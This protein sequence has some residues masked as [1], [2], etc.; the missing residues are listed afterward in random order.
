[1]QLQEQREKQ[2]P[3]LLFPYFEGTIA[4]LA[5]EVVQRRQNFQL[6]PSLEQM[7]KDILGDSFSYNELQRSF[8]PSDGSTLELQLAPH[9]AKPDVMNI[10]ASAL[11]RILTIAGYPARLTIRTLPDDVYVDE[12]QDI[13]GIK[14]AYIT[15]PVFCQTP[16]GPEF[17]VYP[18]I[19]PAEA[20]GKQLRQI[21]I[22]GI[23]LPAYHAEQ[24]R[25][26]GINAGIV[27]GS[28]F[29]A[30]WLR[31]LVTQSGTIADK[32]L[33][34]SR[35]FVRQDDGTRSALS[36]EAAVAQCKQMDSQTAEL[37]LSRLSPS[38]DLYYRLIPTY[39]GGFIDGSSLLL[40]SYEDDQNFLKRV[41]SGVK[42]LETATG[43]VPLVVQCAWLS[44]VD[45]QGRPAFNELSTQWNIALTSLTVPADFIGNKELQMRYYQTIT[46]QIFSQYGNI[47]NVSLTQLHKDILALTIEFLYNRANYANNTGN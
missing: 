16:A 7:M 13:N 40:E 4:Q 35:L 31:Y 18:L 38:A 24:L 39:L 43:K 5:D 41:I 21:M 10:S 25:A 26:A 2:S 47:S 27:D 15:P 45:E 3:E 12:S 46:S 11:T 33:R 32:D 42:K 9:L 8:F 34:K 14:P 28:S 22:N 20:Q 1:M 30:S 19:D 44:G 6:P 36:V 17:T 37:F 23:N 29:H